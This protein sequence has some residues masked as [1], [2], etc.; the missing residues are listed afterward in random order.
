MA[1]DSIGIRR[2]GLFGRQCL[3][4]AVGAS[5]RRW[6]RHR[7]PLA[8]PRHLLSGEVVGAFPSDAPSP[9]K[10]RARFC[11]PRPLPCGR[12]GAPHLCALGASRDRVGERGGHFLL[13]ALHG[14][15]AYANFAGDLDD[16]HAGP[17]T[18]LDALFDGWADPRGRPSVW[19]ASTARLRPA[20][21]R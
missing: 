9:A 16:A 15:I 10:I 20:W 6:Q 18:I 7:C 5:G 13:D 1:V 2:N 8:E 19:P 17:Q 3:H 21:T 11:Q 4:C 12:E 14:A